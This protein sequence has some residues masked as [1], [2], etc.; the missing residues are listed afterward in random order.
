[1]SREI[2]QPRAALHCRKMAQC[3]M[4]RDAF[5]KRCSE[6]AAKVQTVHRASALQAQPAGSSRGMRSRDARCRPR[7]PPLPRCRFRRHAARCLPIRTSARERRGRRHRRH[8]AERGATRY[9]YALCD[10]R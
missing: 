5:S 9:C 8:G 6:V 10:A 4:L 3:E 7:L 1:L 2:L